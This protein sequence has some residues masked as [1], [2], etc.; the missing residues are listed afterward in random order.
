M[1]PDGSSLVVS[2]FGDLL[3]DWYPYLPNA[4]LPSSRKR[5]D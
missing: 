4:N 3:W 2:R 5:L 1:Q